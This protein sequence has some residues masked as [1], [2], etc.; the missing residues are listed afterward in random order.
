M[1]N[2]EGSQR[3]TQDFLSLVFEQILWISRG[4]SQITNTMISSFEEQNKQNILSGLQMLHEDLN[5][6]KQ[7]LR[8]SIESEYQLKVLEE[9]NKELEQ[10]TYVASHD[11][12][13]PLNTIK[14]FVGLIKDKHE[15]TLDEE[16]SV[17]LDFIIQST[18]RMSE[19]IFGLLNY[20]RLGNDTHFENISSQKIIKNVLLDLYAD[21]QKSEAEIYCGH[22]PMVLGNELSLRQVFQNLISNGLK[23]IPKERKAKIFVECEELDDFFVFSVKDNGIGIK[24]EDQEKVF[25]IFHRLETKENFEGTGI[26]LAVCQKIIDIHKGKLWLESEFGKGTTFFFSIPK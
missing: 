25:K 12:Q 24:P 2:K 1:V 18:G 23:F 22:L 13:A 26:G 6:Y 11:L 8:S 5:L 10:F 16:T 14:S 20:S 7:E 21:I 19:L 9:R 4:E 15:H 3:A 17:H